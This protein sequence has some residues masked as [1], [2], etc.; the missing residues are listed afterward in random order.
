MDEGN[1]V[2]R[3]R[4]QWWCEPGSRDINIYLLGFWV[5]Q[6]P[7]FSICIQRL[8]FFKLSEVIG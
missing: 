6:P 5:A 1:R 3:M 7:G 8:A 4:M 2:R